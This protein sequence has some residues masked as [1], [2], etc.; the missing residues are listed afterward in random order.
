MA[1][2]KFKLAPEAVKTLT[3]MQEDI[4]DLNAEIVRAAEVGIDLS[5]AKKTLAEAVKMRAGLLKLYT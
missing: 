1:I 4:D 2:T 5:D 3:D